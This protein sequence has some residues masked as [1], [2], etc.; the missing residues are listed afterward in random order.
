MEIQMNTIKTPYSGLGLLF[1]FFMTGAIWANEPEPIEIVLKP[2]SAVYKMDL[3]EQPVQN[4]VFPVL[5]S[6]SLTVTILAGEDL[7]WKLRLPEGNWIDKQNAANSGIEFNV[8]DPIAPYETIWFTVTA[9]QYITLPNPVSGEYELQVDG[10]NTT[11]ETVPVKISLV[12]S[13]LKTGFGG[14]PEVMLGEP[15]TLSVFLFEETT[16]ITGATVQG[17]VLDSNKLEVVTLEF[18]DDGQGVDYLAGDGLYTAPFDPQQADGYLISANIQGTTS[19]GQSFDAVEGGRLVVNPPDISLTGTYRDQGV[20]EDGDGYFDYIRFEFDTQ[21]PRGSDGTYYL[22]LTLE[23][24]NGEWVYE[25]GRN[26]DP[27]EPITVNIPA[28]TIK[29]LGMDGPYS[30]SHIVLAHDNRTLSR[31]ENLGNSSAYRLDSLERRNTLI[32]PLSADQGIDI[33]GD[34]L[35]DGLE[36]VFGVDVLISGYYGISADLINQQKNHLLDSASIGRTYLSRGFHNITLTFSGEKIGESGQDGPYVLDNVLVY[37]RFQTDESTTSTL[38]EEMGT[39]QPYTCWQF[40]GCQM[41]AN[42]LLERLI[43][44]FEA[45]AIK[46]GLKKGLANSLRVKLKGAKRALDKNKKNAY[47][48]ASLKVKAF[49]NEVHAQ[50]DRSLSK[51]EN[52]AHQKN[53]VLYKTIAEVDAELLIDAANL[54]IEMIDLDLQKILCNYPNNNRK[55]C[56]K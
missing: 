22:R 27:N 6:Q 3:S 20:D 8:A 53:K 41:D 13:G 31:L 4:L 47:K 34:G 15:V 2:V 21:G 1:L 56:D 51:G 7:T 44:Q 11:L 40:A 35:F 12:G 42:A 5:G 33:D 25:S 37:P 17:K 38:A 52:E 55:F 32:Y 24:P 23:A 9:A 26:S 49:I 43:S 50:S 54:L 45:I 46:N 14:K 30:L 28:E 19:E 39:T 16:P 48:V 10:S 29:N 36:V 18:N